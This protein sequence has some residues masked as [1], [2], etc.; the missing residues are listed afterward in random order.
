MKIQGSAPRNLEQLAGQQR[1]IHEGEQ[2]IR[3]VSAQADSEIGRVNVRIF[4]QRNAVTHGQLANGRPPDVL[5]RSIPVGHHETNLIAAGEQL[6]EADDA[7]GVVCENH[8]PE[9]RHARGTDLPR[10]T[11]SMM[12]RGRRLTS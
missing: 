5:V 10:R 9:S 8:A 7:D 11:E 1:S 6:F 12:Y 2:E 3:R 4:E